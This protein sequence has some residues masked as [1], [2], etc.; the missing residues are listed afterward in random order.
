MEM[1]KLQNEDVQ[2]LCSSPNT[3]TMIN[4]KSMRWVGHVACMGKMS[5][6]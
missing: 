5:N 2:N 1:E 4:P 6:A 3:I